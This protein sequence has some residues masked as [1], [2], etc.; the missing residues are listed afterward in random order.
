MQEKH[1]YN[2]IFIFNER[3]D[4]FKNSESIYSEIEDKT[5]NITKEDIELNNQFYYKKQ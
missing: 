1:F 4:A 5:F 3:L 2:S